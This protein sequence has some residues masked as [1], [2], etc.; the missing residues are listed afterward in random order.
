MS[1]RTTEKK[2]RPFWLQVLVVA[3]TLVAAISL[4]IAFVIFG[5]LC[6]YLDT[7]WYYDCARRHGFCDKFRCV[8]ATAR[9]DA[10]PY[11]RSPPS[12]EEMIDH[13]RKHRADFERLV[14]IYGEDPSV[15][16]R[17]GQPTIPPP[18]I[19]AIMQR[20]KVCDMQSDF[21]FWLPPG[22]GLRV[23]RVQW[24]IREK[25]RRNEIEARKYSG[26]FFCYNHEPVFRTSY[27]FS[28]FF[29][30]V[31]KGYYYTPIAPEVVT[32]DPQ[33]PGVL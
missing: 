22:S 8:Y 25:L 19:A 20:T 4:L 12:D 29:P 14:K 13:F 6:W 23:G 11:L 5:E 9:E 33:Y 24:D 17:C 2:S 3:C 21:Q 32:G 7:C 16:I 31:R 1:D 15:R 30:W 26:I 18:A 10:R 27:W 28:L